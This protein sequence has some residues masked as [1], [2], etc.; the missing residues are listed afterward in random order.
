LLV[1]RKEVS[2]CLCKEL[3]VCDVA[4][5]DGVRCATEF[6]GVV[7]ELELVDLMLATLCAVVGGRALI[8]IGGRFVGTLD[9]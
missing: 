7:F 5:D 4:R 1:L 8:C 3:I 9:F 6:V 2:D